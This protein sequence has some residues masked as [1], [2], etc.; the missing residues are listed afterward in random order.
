ME[1]TERKARTKI[2]IRLRLSKPAGRGN[3]QATTTPAS[4][5]SV[6]GDENSPF[7]R[8]LRNLLNLYKIT[9]DDSPLLYTLKPWEPN[10]MFTKAGVIE[11]HALMH[12]RLDLLLRHVAS[13]PDTL[14]HKPIP[15][16]GHPSISKQFVHILTCEEGWVR[17]L[18]DKTFVGWSEQEYPTIAALLANKN[19]IREETRT[20][21]KD[22]TQEQFETTLAKRPEDWGGELRSP[23]F[24]LLHVITHAFHHKGQVVAM[25]RILGYPAPDTDLQQV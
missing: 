8:S 13:V 11:F 12:D 1:R 9:G 22:L 17:S 16:F 21:L 24:I 2:E 25:L 5:G 3:L 19:R 18:Q 6:D 15:G 4:V 23:A 20:Y 7:A 14:L 10:I